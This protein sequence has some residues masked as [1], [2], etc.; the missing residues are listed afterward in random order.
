MLLQSARNDLLGPV[1]GCQRAFHLSEV[2]VIA[3]P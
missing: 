1:R 3:L 2:Q